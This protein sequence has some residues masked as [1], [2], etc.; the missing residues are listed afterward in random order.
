MR[1]SLFI[2][3]LVIVAGCRHSSRIPGDFDYGKVE[4]GIYINKYFDMEVSVPSGWIVQSKKQADRVLNKEYKAIEETN[5][6]IACR[7]QKSAASTAV[8]LFVFKHSSDSVTNGYNPYFIVMAE[9]LDSL[10]GIK[11]GIDYLENEKNLMHQAK[12]GYFVTSDYSLK[13]IGNKEFDVLRFTKSI[14][15]QMDVK[16]VYHVWIEKGFALDIII[17]F[18]FEEQEKELM[19]VLRKI[20]FV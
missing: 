14:G 5:K 16:R 13:N 11:T 4:N 6:E 17:S 15:E 20:R 3:L 19:D 1:S 9:K 12:T 8:L 10:S 7:T 18:A 2:F